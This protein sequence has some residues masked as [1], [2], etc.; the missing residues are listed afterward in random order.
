[1]NMKETTGLGG[2]VLLRSGGAWISEILRLGTP[3][4]HRGA[5]VTCWEGEL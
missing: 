1:M 5:L 3:R 2:P 4:Q